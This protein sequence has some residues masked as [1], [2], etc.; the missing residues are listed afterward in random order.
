[1]A[2]FLG[3]EDILALFGDDP[4][5]AQMQARALADAMQRRRAAGTIATV[6]GGPFAQ[7]GRAFLGEAGQTQDDLMRAGQFRANRDLAREKM[8]TYA[9]DNEA[10]A[11]D[12]RARLDLQQQN[13]DLQR[14]RL[15]KAPDPSQPK[16]KDASKSY[17]GEYLTPAAQELPDAQRNDLM[18]TLAGPGAEWIDQMAELSAVLE[19]AGDAP[20]PNQI[21][22]I[23]RLI[24]S[25]LTKQNKVAGLGALS[26]PDMELLK[27]AGGSVGELT[28][29]LGQ[30][31]G[32]RDLKRSVRS[33][34]ERGA[35]DI[36]IRA[37]GYGAKPV[38]G[39][40]LDFATFDT[41][42]AEYLKKWKPGKVGAGGAVY[43]RMQ[44]KDGKWYVND[45][46]GWRAE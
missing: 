6:I 24:A 22:D 34:A 44:G 12:R 8:T 41:R 45:G 40:K 16:P 14:Q 9:P 37:G 46:S 10:L 3:Q 1:M 32:L 17:L 35:R 27:K 23:Q 5:A 42:A 7:A 38:P 36:E 29:F 20:S 25:G 30:A 18:N 2:D 28:N 31:T 4:A 43:S 11:A 19:A 21:A 39:G 13:L 15:S 33:A 26:G